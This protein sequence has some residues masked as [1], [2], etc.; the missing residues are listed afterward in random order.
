MNVRKALATIT[1]AGLLA[2]TLCVGA[3]GP[4]SRA[5]GK[6]TTVVPKFKANP[7]HDDARL[8]ENAAQAAQDGLNDLGISGQDYASAVLDGF[9]YS[10]DD[11]TVN[12]QAATVSMTVVSKSKTDFYNKLNDAVSAFVANP[13]TEALS[14]GEKDTQMGSITMQAFE[15]TETVGESIQLQ[16]QLQGTTWVSVNSGEVLGNLD[17]FA[18]QE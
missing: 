9:D 1:A 5:D 14:E 15:Q 12:E 8:S 7:S 16:F 10:I 11:I 2:F 17:S 6:P 18:F 4:P 3:R 13:G